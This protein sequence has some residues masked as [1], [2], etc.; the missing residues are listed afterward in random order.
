MEHHSNIVPWQLVCEQTGAKL[1]V[2]PITDTGELD[3]DAFRR[4][5]GPRTK[6]VAVTYVS[7]ALGTVNP[8]AELAPRRTRREPWSSST[9]RKPC[10][11]CA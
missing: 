4:L 3:R 7:N 6:I 9:P 11:T 2:A 5:L 10:R 8:V 1:V